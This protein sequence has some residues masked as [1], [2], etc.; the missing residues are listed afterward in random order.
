MMQKTETYAAN[1]KM[2]KKKQNAEN[3]KLKNMQK[4]E[5]QCTKMIFFF[6]MPCRKHKRNFFF[7]FSQFFFL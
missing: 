6:W 4:T 3:Q 7:S 1:Q 5:T 2:Q